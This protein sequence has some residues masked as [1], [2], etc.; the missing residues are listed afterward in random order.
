[1][2]NICYIC[3]VC[4]GTVGNHI[5]WRELRGFK[6]FIGLLE[7]FLLSRSFFFYISIFSFRI[8]FSEYCLEVFFFS[9]CDHTRWN[10]LFILET[11][12]V[13]LF[14]FSFPS[15]DASPSH[16]RKKKKKETSIIIKNKRVRR[17][18]HRDIFLAW[19]QQLSKCLSFAGCS[20]VSFCCC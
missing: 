16:W 12:Q 4:V 17:H 2:Q 5:K 18:T 14:L 7:N 19:C 6:S 3:Y 1:M 9:T 20:A 15:D 11:A 10:G 13:S 8:Y